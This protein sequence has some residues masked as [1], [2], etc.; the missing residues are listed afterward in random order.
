F[1]Y[2]KDLAQLSAVDFA[3]AAERDSD[4]F[5]R[6]GFG[7]LLAGRAAGLA[8]QHSTPAQFIEVDR[9]VAVR[10]PSGTINARTAIVT[11]ST[12]VLAAGRIRFAPEL[13]QRVNEAFHSLSLGSYD[14]VALELA[15][16]PLGL[17]S[18]DLV[19]EKSTDARTTAILGN[20]S[21]TAL[22]LIEVAGSF[23]QQL[24]AQGEVA[25]VDFAGDWLTKH[26]GG[27]VRKAIRRASA[28][29]WNADV[30]ALG[31]MSAAMPG[32]HG[33]RAVLAQPV[34]EAIWFA[35]EAVHET[36]WGTVG[37]AWESGERAA[38]AVLRRLAGQREPEAEERRPKRKRRVRR[39]Y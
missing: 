25:M 13:P 33:A 11:V 39:R 37:G 20:V 19:F 31:A 8:I 15:G 28:T 16:N 32:G 36:L 1:A 38:D 35:G 14:H 29:R 34:R 10:T 26:F 9:G 5:C 27:S 24:S 7:A 4:A 18:D 21:G 2:G 22:C 3:R 17:D 30:F 12:N 6:Q 23:G